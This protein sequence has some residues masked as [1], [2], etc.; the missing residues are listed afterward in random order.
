MFVGQ[1]QELDTKD[2]GLRHAYS[3]PRVVKQHISPDPVGEG[4]LRAYLR[5][6]WYKPTA[7]T[8]PGL[9]SPPSKISPRRHFVCK[10]V[11]RRDYA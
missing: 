10:R 9:S 2:A 8:Q 5:V 6:H 4:G 11:G 3:Q 7:H 1:C